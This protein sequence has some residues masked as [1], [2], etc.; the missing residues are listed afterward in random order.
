MQHLITP[1][2]LLVNTSLGIEDTIQVGN[3]DVSTSLRKYPRAFIDVT[4]AGVENDKVSD[5]KHHGGPN[6]ALHSFSVEYRTMFMRAANKWESDISH[7]L[8]GE[9]LTTVCFTDETVH[10]GDVISV[11]TAVLQVTMPTERCVVPGAACDMPKLLKWM[12]GQCRTGFYLRVLAPGRIRPG[13]INLIKRNS[14]FSIAQLSAVMYHE[15]KNKTLVEHV[16]DDRFI[17]EEWKE[18]LQKRIAKE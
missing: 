1:Q 15:F 16:L 9:N 8:V 18:S 17:A 14:Q 2:V 7:A 4:E 10:V 13:N 6:R 11:G 3:R 5:K 12:V